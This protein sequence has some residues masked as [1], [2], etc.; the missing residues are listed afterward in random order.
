MY[1][2][3]TF[4]YFSN[5]KHNSGAINLNHIELNDNN[6]ATIKEGSFEGIKHEEMKIE[7]YENPINCDCHLSWFKDWH[8]EV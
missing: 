7:M 2:R 3:C 6:I 8:K 5:T 1:L 4:Q